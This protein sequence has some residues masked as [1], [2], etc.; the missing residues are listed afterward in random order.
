ML[1]V[2]FAGSHLAEVEVRMQSWTQLESG[3]GESV[4]DG[5]RLG[6]YF[7]SAFCYIVHVM[8]PTLFPSRRTE[9]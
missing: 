9:K 6:Y 5:E 1:A 7:S 2:V 8:I 3:G 4:A